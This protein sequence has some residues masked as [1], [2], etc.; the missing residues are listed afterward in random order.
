MLSK[1]ESRIRK[2]GCN[3]AD[4]EVL[5]LS[6]FEAWIPKLGCEVDLTKPAW[7][8]TGNQVLLHIQMKS[9]A[10]NSLAPKFEVFNRMRT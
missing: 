6:K 4:V 5:M 9:D 2:R 7:S 3:E 8:S 10:R 1:L